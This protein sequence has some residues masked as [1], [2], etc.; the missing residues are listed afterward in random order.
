MNKY[1]RLEINFDYNRYYEGEREN[2]NGY[3]KNKV[4]KEGSEFFILCGTGDKTK[5]KEKLKK[6]FE[7]YCKEVLE[8]FN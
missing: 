3:T 8:K 7:K 5:S 1:I 2:L 4:H 6:H